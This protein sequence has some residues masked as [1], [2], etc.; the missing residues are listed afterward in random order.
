MIDR[1][2][3]IYARIDRINEIVTLLN[4]IEELKNETKEYFESYDKLNLEENK[5]FENWE[6]HLEDTLMRLEHIVL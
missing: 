6:N 2:R 5:I 4:E 3:E 1:K